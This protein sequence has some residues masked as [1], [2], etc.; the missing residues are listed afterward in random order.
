MDRYNSLQIQKG[1]RKY[2]LDITQFHV[3]I[4]PENI[5]RKFFQRA[6]ALGNAAKESW[7]PCKSVACFKPCSALKMGEKYLRVVAR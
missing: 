3:K 4:L 2:I 1:Q 6:D 5:I 7:S